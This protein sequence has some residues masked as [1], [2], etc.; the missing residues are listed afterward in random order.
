MTLEKLD[1]FF[2]F[3]VFFYGFLLL[4][5]QELPFVRALGDAKSQAMMQMLSKR[6]PLA[7]T[8]LLIGAV[9]SLQNLVFA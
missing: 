4:L 7:W 1:F 9:W 8:C 5:V 6:S 3:F 2:P